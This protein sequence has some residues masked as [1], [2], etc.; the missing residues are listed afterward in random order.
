M[1]N[2]FTRYLLGHKGRVWWKKSRPFSRYCTFKCL[3]HN[4]EALRYEKLNIKLSTLYT[5][6]SSLFLIRYLQFFEHIVW[7][8]VP[9]ATL[10]FENLQIIVLIGKWCYLYMQSVIGTIGLN[11]P[12]ENLCQL[13]LICVRSRVP[14]VSVSTSVSLSIFL[15]VSKRRHECFSP[16]LQLYC[17]FT[18]PFMWSSRD[19]KNLSHESGWLK[20]AGNLGASPFKR[21]LSTDSIYRQIHLA[22]RSLSATN[23]KRLPILISFGR[24]LLLTLAA[25]HLTIPSLKL[26]LLASR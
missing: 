5:S 4:I 22:G 1:Q 15:S 26:P 20:S 3:Q 16:I 14:F 7:R 8:A 2:W 18:R 11:W 17:W 24:W 6:V 25:L 19:L 21:D 9:A 12:L 10:A 23:S 13:W